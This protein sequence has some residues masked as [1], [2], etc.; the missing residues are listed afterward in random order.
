MG[1]DRLRTRRP[2]R[3]SLA[4]RRPRDSHRLR[5]LLRLAFLAATYRL[6][7]LTPLTTTSLTGKATDL[8]ID[9]WWTKRG[10][11]VSD[12][13]LNTALRAVGAQFN[14]GGGKVTAAPSSNASA[15]NVDP[16]QYL[17][18][19]G[20]QQVTSYQPD[21]RYW[22]FQGIEFGWLTGLAIILLA[23]TFWLL[24]RRPA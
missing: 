16:V 15:N 24:R 20:Y 9:E 3:A 13:Q 6:H 10:V 23:I 8:P 17:L 12:D 22:A 18:H 19:H 4:P 1:S 21:S 11:R 14:S 5:C 7:Y 2:G